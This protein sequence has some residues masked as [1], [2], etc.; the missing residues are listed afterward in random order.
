MTAAGIVETLL[1]R[2]PGLHRFEWTRARARIPLVQQTQAADCGAACLAMVLR[3]R[4]SFVPLDELIQHL[5]G[6]RNG[7]SAHAIIQ[8][9]RAYGLLGRGLHVEVE[10][11][12]YLQSGSVLHWQFD[13]FV[14]FAAVH[15]DS[16]E[17]VDPALG[18]RRVPLAEFAES[19]TGVA[20]EFEHLPDFVRVERPRSALLRVAYDASMRSGLLPRIL[21]VSA[22]LQLVTFFVPMLLGLI[23]D[24]VIPQGDPRLLWVVTTACAIGVGFAAITNLVRN[25]LLLS[26]RIQLDGEL[27]LG[28]L[29]HLVSLP[30]SF[31]QARPAGDL[32]LRVNSN[33]SIREALSTDVLLI[34]IDGTFVVIALLVLAIGNPIFA[35][36]VLSLAL[37]RWIPGAVLQSKVRE[38]L[39]QELRARGRS[40]AVLVDLLSGMESLKAMGREGSALEKWTDRFVDELNIRL[41][42]GRL[43]AWVETLRA[44]MESS[45][46]LL[47]L[48]FGA[49]QVL[50]HRLELG[51]MLASYALAQG[52]LAP[53]S[54]LARTTSRLLSIRAYAEVMDDVLRAPPEVPRGVIRPKPVLQGGLRAE[55][56]SF[57][58]SPRSPWIVQDFSVQVEPGQ[59]IALVGP[60]GSGKSTAARLLLGLYPPEMGRIF[61]DGTDIQEIDPT[62]FRRQIGVVTQGAALFGN[63]VREAITLR[64]SLRLDE[65]RAAARLACIDEAVM[66]LPMTYETPVIEGVSSFSGGE[67]Q[68][69][70]IARAL[71]HRP[72]ILLLDEATSALDAVTEARILKNLADLSCTRIVIAHRMSTIM[73]A[74]LILV[75]D[76][77]RVV[78]QGRH[79]QLL[80]NGRLYTR[81]IHGSAE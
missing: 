73:A 59:M 40:Q 43:D 58:Y 5:G 36:V 65:V 23:V 49:W 34:L 37:I 15:K 20:I 45:A 63:T 35:L 51:P 76:G 29:H 77:G 57:R 48:V 21:G 64:S 81:L 8:V 17:I 25:H 27:T 1:E 22:L 69:F 75:F 24:R 70:A 6:G 31:F 2:I 55:N 4:G 61:Y 56:V 71:A 18:R 33:A 47:L 78:E 10:D 67:R 14:V 13:H 38:Y 74:D 62:F 72:R 52:A 41:G 53:I 32:L 26:L 19:F 11:L 44:V 42:R 79:D 46:P 68:R 16:V 54:E 80:K 66:A 9:A 7:V 30:F 39:A 60:S 12:S 50:D 28:F 3:Q